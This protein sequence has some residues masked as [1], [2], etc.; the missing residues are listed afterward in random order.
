MPWANGTQDTPASLSDAFLLLSL[1]LSR[2]THAPQP[3][4]CLSSCNTPPLAL[5]L[6]VRT[7]L[8]LVTSISDL[9]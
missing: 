8:V 2:I 9:P 1:D 5:S 4:I 6:W 3:A 7:S